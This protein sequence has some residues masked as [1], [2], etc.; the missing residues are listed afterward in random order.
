MAINK[1]K[2]TVHNKNKKAVKRNSHSWN[3]F[4]QKDKVNTREHHEELL[5]QL[6]KVAE[7]ILNGSGKLT[8]FAHEYFRKS[9]LRENINNQVNEG[10]TNLGK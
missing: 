9:H 6:E 3:P 1:L 10:K 2:K 4:K 8:T 5:A 7:I